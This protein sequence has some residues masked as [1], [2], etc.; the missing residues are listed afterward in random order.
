MSGLTANNSARIDT[1]EGG[2]GVQIDDLAIVVDRRKE[3]ARDFYSR[4]G[5][6]E[7]KI[8]GHLAGI[9]FKKPVDVVELKKGT[10]LTQYQVPGSDQGNYYSLAIDR[11]TPGSLG[12][13]PQAMERTSGLIVDK[14]P[15]F[16]IVD[17]PTEALR[18]TAASIQDT[19][20]IPGRSIATQGGATQFYIPNKTRILPK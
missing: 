9:D 19:W 3:I 12:I 16:Y 11:A 13:S 20:S 17:N 18:S 6:P 8:D 15:N 5:M 1:P 10:V 4:S 2:H 14:V 7:Y